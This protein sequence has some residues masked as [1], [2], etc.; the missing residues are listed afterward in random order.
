MPLDIHS[1][2]ALDTGVAGFP[3]HEWEGLHFEVMGTTVCHLQEEPLRPEGRHRGSLPALYPQT[4][5]PAPVGM[6]HD[7]QD[8]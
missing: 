6:L 5:H 8:P 3:T 2:G 7:I 4:D 1:S